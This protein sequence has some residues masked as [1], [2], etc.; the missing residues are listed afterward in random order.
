MSENRVNQPIYRV[1]NTMVKG[2]GISYTLNNKYDAQ[3]L[4]TT[5][6]NYETEL[7]KNKTTID[8]DKLN[9]QL[10][11]LKLT[12]NILTDEIQRLEELIQ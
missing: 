8:T 7:Q 1:S 5:L 10:I 3:Q 12:I 11:Q 9:K 6:N 4:C 2:K